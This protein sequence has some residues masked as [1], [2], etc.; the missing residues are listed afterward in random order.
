MLER[1][2]LLSA[3]MQAVLTVDGHGHGWSGR[4]CWQLRTL[5][6]HRQGG[7]PRLCVCV[8]PSAGFLRILRE[9]V[10]RT[11]PVFPS[12]SESEARCGA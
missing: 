1:S 2:R 8:C 5:G 6:S 7:Q 9:A 12:T 10:S 11:S 4:N 3:K